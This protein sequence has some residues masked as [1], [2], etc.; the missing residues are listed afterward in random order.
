MTGENDVTNWKGL[1]K[2]GGIVGIMVTFFIPLQGIIFAVWPPPDKV[3]DWFALFQSNCFIGLL[4][5]DLLLTIDYV[6]LM[7]FFI[8]LWASLKH[9]NQSLMAIALVLEVLSITSYLASTTAFEMLSLSNQYSVATTD[10]EKFV[11]LA[12]GQAMLVIW[13]GTAFNVSYI[14]GAIA[15]FTVS[16]VMLRS[17]IFSKATAYFGLAGSILMI[18]P[19][20]FGKIGVILS[21]LSLLPTIPWLILTAGTFFKLSK[22]Q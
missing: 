3:I 6:I 4:D 20:S 5:M 22:K 7:I 18:V 8:A 14:L 1:Y 9:V 10:Q 16:T 2:I 11:L 13:Q 19:P 12:A 15:M 21:F 17:N